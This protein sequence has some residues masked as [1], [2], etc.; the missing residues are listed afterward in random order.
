MVSKVLERTEAAT[1]TRRRLWVA[2]A[3]GTSLLVIGAVM[4]PLLERAVAALLG[5]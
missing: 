4:R 1:W 2:V 3:A 5:G